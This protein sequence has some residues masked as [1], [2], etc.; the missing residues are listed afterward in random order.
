MQQIIIDNDVEKD[1]KIKLY[2]RS[3]GAQEGSEAFLSQLRLNVKQDGE[4]ELFDA[5]ADE[6]AQLSDWVYLGTI[7][8][9]GKITL[10]VTLD[11]PLT[12]GDEFQKA[13]GYLDWRFKVE[14]LP[15]EP[16]DPSRRRP[17]TAT[18]FRFG[19][20]CCSRARCWRYSSS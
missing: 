5:P 20:C 10:D 9:G 2:I 1:V 6:T 11:V 12:L 17:A 15:V 3:D 16:D 14:E 13:I 4:S 8:S 18:A 19:A 7:Y